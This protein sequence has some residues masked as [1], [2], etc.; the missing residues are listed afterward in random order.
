MVG[1][2]DIL[3]KSCLS[4]SYRS[5]TEQGAK[6][7]TLV[8]SVL[9][10]LY[11]LPVTTIDAY[12][13]LLRNSM[14]NVLGTYRA[15]CRQPDAQVSSQ[16]QNGIGPSFP[17]ATRYQQLPN[18]SRSYPCIGQSLPYVLVTAMQCAAG[19]SIEQKC[20]TVA[21]QSTYTICIIQSFLRHS[22]YSLQYKLGLKLKKL[23]FR[24]NKI[25][26]IWNMVYI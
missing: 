19:L 12:F 7:A 9:C 11:N 26:D 10:P 8:L 22:V 20:N 23:N 6:E 5:S 15:Q 3:G 24:I 1:Q 18:L 2:N 25:W 21:Q 4:Q 16:W 14:W 13:F 17:F